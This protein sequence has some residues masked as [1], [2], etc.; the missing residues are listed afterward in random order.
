MRDGGVRPEG[1]PHPVGRALDGLRDGVAAPPIAGRREGRG[2]KLGPAAA[3]HL[4]N[5]NEKQYYGVQHSA[6]ARTLA[7]SHRS[8]RLGLEISQLW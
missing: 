4:N 8:Q 6:V 3:A 2:S 5:K 7:S 1:D